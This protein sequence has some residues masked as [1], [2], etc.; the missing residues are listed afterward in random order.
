VVEPN[1][2]ISGCAGVNAKV[3]AVRAQAGASFWQSGPWLPYLRPSASCGTAACVEVCICEYM[4]ILV[5][6]CVFVR[7]FSYLVAFLHTHTHTL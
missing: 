1:G 5:C 4:C 7:E 2:N 6:T 3:R